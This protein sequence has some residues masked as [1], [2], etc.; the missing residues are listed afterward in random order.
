VQHRTAPV[1]AL[2]LMQQPTVAL[3]GSYLGDAIG[4][5]W[6]LRDLVGVRAVS[7]LGSR[8]GS[9]H[10]WWRSGTSRTSRVSQS[11]SSYALSGRSM[12]RSAPGRLHRT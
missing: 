8:S 10:G 5:G 11:S 3:W 1:E 7:H 12:P 2:Q 6:S 4:T 9:E